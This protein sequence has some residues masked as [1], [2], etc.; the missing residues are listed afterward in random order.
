MEGRSGLWVAASLGLIAGLVL[1]LSVGRFSSALSPELRG[2]IIGGAVGIVTTVVGGVFNWMQ[3]RSQQRFGLRQGVYLEAAAALGRGVEYFTSLGRTD[4]DNNQLAQMLSPG[5]VATSRIQMVG[6]QATID[7]LAKTGETLAVSVLKMAK[8]RIALQAAQAKVAAAGTE[9][10]QSTAYLQQLGSMIDNLAKSDQV[11]GEIPGLVAQL[12][13]ARDRVRHGQTQL[14][15]ASDETLAL[16]KTL[17]M[18]GLEAALEYQQQL[19]EVN[20]AARR[21]LGLPLNEAKYRND[22]KE[23]ASRMKEIV[24]RTVQELEVGGRVEPHQT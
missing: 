12:P 11:H 15:V 9:L 24:H 20:I 8:G 21:E 14:V 3:Y 19:V 4:L 13:G 18:E 16:Q 2:V 7:A 10:A 5:T 23:S 6:T 17:F 22:V 1:D